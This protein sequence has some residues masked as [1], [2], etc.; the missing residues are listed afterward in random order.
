MRTRQ[1]NTPKQ[2]DV[3]LDYKALQKLGESFLSVGDDEQ[4][5][6]CYEKAAILDPD[7]AAPYVGIG[8]IAMQKNLPDDA[9]LAFRVACR[10]DPKCSGAYE[11]LGMVAQHNGNHEKAFE[12]Y[13]KCLELDTN[14]LAALLGLFQASSQMGSFAKI[15]HYLEVYLDMHPNDSTVMFTLATL[16]IKEDQFEKSK[17]MLLKIREISPD[18]EDAES[19]LE[20]VEQN[21]ARTISQ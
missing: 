4:A 19:L 9:E 18:N 8:I 15:I 3:L 1:S 14:N 17:K 5:R 12:M 13:L 2:E 6:Q 16:Y 20:E 11:G 21:L 10:L 7:E